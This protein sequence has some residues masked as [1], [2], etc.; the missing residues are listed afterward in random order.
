MGCRYDMLRTNRA[1]FGLVAIGLVASCATSA[2]QTIVGVW[3]FDQSVEPD[4]NHDAEWICMTF[5]DDGQ[6]SIV[7]ALP[8]GVATG[9]L[10]SYSIDNNT[11]QLT[12]EGEASYSVRIQLSDAS[13][14][15]VPIG[16]DSGKA[17][18][19]LRRTESCE[20]PG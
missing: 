7:G 12:P 3:L 10:G 1:L 19:V 15:L 4:Q 9:P 2:E 17:S 20:R 8:D 14:K 18:I 5:R 11:L 6:F 13:L 16:D